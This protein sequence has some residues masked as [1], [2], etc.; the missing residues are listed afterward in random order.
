MVETVSVGRVHG[1]GLHVPVGL[2]HTPS[3]QTACMLPETVYPLWQFIKHETPLAVLLLLQ[4]PAAELANVGRPMQGFGLQVPVG[5]LHTPSEHVATALP[6]KVY[7]V[8]HPIVQDDALGV[9]P[10]EQVFATEL[11]SV[12][13][14][15]H[16]LGLHEPSDVHTPLVHVCAAPAVYPP[17]H[18]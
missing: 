14:P 18:M 11:A 5:L 12:G 16:A 15:V 6:D 17:R 10:A 13:R 1:L 2:P 4:L 8:W 7:P 3:V 9:V